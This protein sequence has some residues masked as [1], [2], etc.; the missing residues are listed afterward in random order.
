MLAYPWPPFRSHAPTLD[1]GLRSD[2][3]L[4]QADEDVVDVWE[5]V[6]VHACLGQCRQL[7]TLLISS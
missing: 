2:F 6:S 1:N 5:R 4:L 3:T 7:R